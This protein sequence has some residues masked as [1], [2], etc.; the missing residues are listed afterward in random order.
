VQPIEAVTALKRDG[1][2][3]THGPHWVSRTSALAAFYYSITTTAIGFL[4]TEGEGARPVVRVSVVHENDR[5]WCRPS[6]P[7]LGYNGVVFHH[8]KK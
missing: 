5:H 3:L 2:R 7:T 1:R 6:R 8:L 4:T